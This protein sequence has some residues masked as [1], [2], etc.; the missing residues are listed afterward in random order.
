MTLPLDELIRLA[1]HGQD[2]TGR[3]GYEPHM[4][5]TKAQRIAAVA[6]MDAI[7]DWE[8]EEGRSA[9]LSTGQIAEAVSRVADLGWAVRDARI[10][11]ADEEEALGGA[12]MEWA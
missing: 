6:V 2:A 11:L 9:G 3:I 5:P 12:K 7:L 8:F 1:A 4:S 10:A